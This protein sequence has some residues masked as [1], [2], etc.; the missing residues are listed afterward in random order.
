MAVPHCSIS[1]SVQMHQERGQSTFTPKITSTSCSLAPQEA[2]ALPVTGEG[3]DGT[4]DVCPEQC[5]SGATDCSIVL[6]SVLLVHSWPPRLSQLL[7]GCTGP[8]LGSG[9]FGCS[10]TSCAPTTH[11]LGSH[12]VTPSMAVC[13]L[14]ASGQ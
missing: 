2:E 11:P 5:C 12:K 3:A 8:T 10:P 7:G 13:W 4:A 9:A 6:S 1:C 14:G